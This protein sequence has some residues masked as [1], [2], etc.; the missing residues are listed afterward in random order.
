MQAHKNSNWMYVKKKTRIK[1]TKSWKIFTSF[2]KSNKLYLRSDLN[3]SLG[4]Q[5]ASVQMSSF[6][7]MKQNIWAK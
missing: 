2:G 1:N 4:G 5:H 3:T 7:A 6:R